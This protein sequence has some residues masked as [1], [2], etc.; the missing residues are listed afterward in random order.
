MTSSNDQDRSVPAE[1]VHH[2]DGFQRGE[3]GVVVQLGQLVAGERALRTAND[4][5]QFIVLCCL[6]Y[7]SDVVGVDRVRKACV[8]AGLHHG[9]HSVRLADLI[10][11]QFKI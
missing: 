7:L 8:A 9:A 5:I 4:Q 11:L 1:A 3:E 6:S 2:A 10:L